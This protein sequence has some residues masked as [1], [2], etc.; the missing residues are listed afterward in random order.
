MKSEPWTRR[1]V[2]VGKDIASF[3]LSH[4]VESS[5]SPAS[6]TACRKKLSFRELSLRADATQYGPI[7]VNRVLSS[8]EVS[9][10]VSNVAGVRNNG[11]AAG[12]SAWEQFLRGA[13]V[14]ESSCAS[15]VASR[16]RKGRVIRSWVRDHHSFR[17]VPEEILEVIGL[18]RRLRKRWHRED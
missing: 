1:C 7:L 12:P 9:L 14:S 16:S 8:A 15:L 17:Y 18:R 2:A 10:T 3:D 6:Y 13:G 4:G 5:R 11:V